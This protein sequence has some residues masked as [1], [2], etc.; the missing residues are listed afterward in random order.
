MSWSRPDSCA[1]GSLLA[2]WQYSYLL[3]AM[4][5]LPSLA[6]TTIDAFIEKNN[7]D[8]LDSILAH[9]RGWHDSYFGNVF[10]ACSFEVLVGWRL[11]MFLPGSGSFFVNYMLQATLLG[12]AFDLMHLRESIVLLWRTHRAVTPKEIEDAI[13]PFDFVYVHNYPLM[14]SYFSVCAA[15]R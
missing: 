8:Q 7:N 9:V 5:V 3:L 6:L 12:N 1:C 13:K 11:Q 4:V 10:V 14:L 15:Y 2:Q